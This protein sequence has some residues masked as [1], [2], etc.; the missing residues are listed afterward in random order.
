LYIIDNQYTKK[1]G[2]LFVKIFHVDGMLVCTTK[3]I[4]TEIIINL[5]LFLTEIHTTSMPD[6][7]FNIGFTPRRI[8]IT[9]VMIILFVPVSFGRG[10]V[11]L[12]SIGN[13]SPWNSTASWSMS[14]N[15]TPAGLTPQANDTV[16]VNTTLVQNINFAFSDNGFL[17]VTGTGL[18]RGDNLTLDFSGNATLKCSGEMKSGKLSFNNNATLLLEKNGKIIVKNSFEMSSQNNLTIAGILQ[19]TG[20]LSI[21]SSS[22]ILG[23]GIITS[24]NF[25]GEG[26]VYSIS[27]ASIIPAGSTISECNWLGA[28]NTNWNDPMNW[29]NGNVPAQISNISILAASYNPGITGRVTCGNLYI[30]SQAAVTVYPT[31]VLDVTGNLTVAGSG[32]LLLKNTTVE[33]SS[34][35]L[36]GEATG[37]IQSEY[38][39]VAGRK[40]LVSSPVQAALSGT[41]LNMYLRPYDENSAQWGEYIIPTDEPMQVMKGYE[42]YSLS[43]ETRVFEGIPNYSAASFAISNSG[44][45]LN[46][47][48]NPFPSY[49]D[50]E[51]NNDNSWQRNS[52]ASAVYYPDPSSSGNLSVYI[53][54][55]DDAVSLNNGSRYLAPMQ[56]FFVKA[57]QEGSLTIPKNSCVR[58]L[59]DVKTIIKNNSIKFR[60]ND[61]D[62]LSDEV[63]FRILEN[64]TFGFDNDLDAL[65]IQA[66][67]GAPSLHLE[68]EG[69]IKYAVSTIPTI[70]SSLNIPLDIECSKAGMY[71]ISTS[72]SFNF[73]YR[74]PV[75]LEDKEL[76][77]MIDLRTDSVYT[78][79]HTPEMNS[80]RFEIHFSSPE[81]IE[82]QDDIT[83]TVSVSEGEVNVT[84]ADSEI[85]TAN[86]FAVDGKLVDSAIGVLSEGIH[87]STRNQTAGIC[88]LQLVKG[89]HTITKKIYTK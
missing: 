86:L 39:V 69:D 5:P 23:N 7:K 47:T 32:K 53:P 67:T 71:K 87:L 58:D 21:G 83:T 11:K 72:G 50:W 59:N 6:N 52:V 40:N 76:N 9:I 61:S 74:Y 75:I 79:Y 77:K 68:S 64:S 60:V 30:N 15:G 14:E 2:I 89:K 26:I 80:K 51:N 88:I 82:Q 78:F 36:G 12:Y 4:Y 84:G 63:L 31:A 29:S 28:Q 46:L 37:N 45:G 8:I 10:A 3:S 62:G 73:E 22:A 57:G 13:N 81:G 66:N 35:V 55:G 33:K 20:N 38:V 16:I 41:F 65:K 18:L 56:G 1:S 17:E 25:E 85:Y 48:G 49:I 43:S 42:L 70:N 24:A 27:P 44:D 19:V 34:L 54:G